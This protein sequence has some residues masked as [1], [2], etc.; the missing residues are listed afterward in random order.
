[1]NCFHTK[2]VINYEK[3]LTASHVAGQFL[4]RRVWRF[5]MVASKGLK[6]TE[7]T[8]FVHRCPL[9]LFRSLRRL[10]RNTW[11]SLILK[12]FKGQKNGIKV[13]ELNHNPNEK[14]TKK[15]TYWVIWKITRL[16]I[17]LWSVHPQRRLISS[18]F[19]SLTGTGW[20][21]FILLECSKM[22]IWSEKNNSNLLLLPFYIW[23]DKP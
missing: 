6:L 1:M 15:K 13:S 3:L 9:I 4:W 20:W 8:F 22:L 14:I 7:V 2:H 12:S 21:D 17:P 10:I 18:V 19:R 11:T 16:T 23:P 5:Q